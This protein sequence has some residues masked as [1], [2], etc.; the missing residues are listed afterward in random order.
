MTTD[1]QFLTGTGGA[2][3]AY[4]PAAR[5]SDNTLAAATDTPIVE[6]TGPILG[7]LTDT[8]TPDITAT[9]ASFSLVSL[10]KG[11]VANLVTLSGKLPTALGARTAASSLSVTPATDAVFPAPLDQSVY[12]HTNGKKVSIT[13]SA[14]V[15]TPP[16]ACKYLRISCDADVVVNTAG[17]AAVDDG[18]SVRIIANRPEVIPVVPGT[19]V[20]AL[21][22]GSSAAV[23][24]ATPMKARS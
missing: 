12:D 1:L 2:S 18:T 22:L 16:A 20:Y 9:N 24:R 23:V 19:A 21:S 15:I 5:K 3:R 17:V 7:A 14:L 8:A 4:T 11:M 10:M 6:V 13:D